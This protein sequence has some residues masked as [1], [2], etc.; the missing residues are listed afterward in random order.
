MILPALVLLSARIVAHRL[1]EP[2]LQRIARWL[3]KSGG[4]MTAWVVGDCRLPDRPRRS[5]PDA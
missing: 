2:L 5:Q 1:V 3:E 4:E